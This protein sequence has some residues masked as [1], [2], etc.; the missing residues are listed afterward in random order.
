MPDRQPLRLSLFLLCLAL[1]GARLGGAHLHLCLDGQEALVS[2][3]ASEPGH[4]DAHHGDP[5]HSDVDVSLVSDALT[6]LAKL[7][8]DL[9]TLLAVLWLVLGAR[10][11]RVTA[12]STRL[13][14]RASQAR[15]HHPPLRGPPSLSR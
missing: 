1:L 3:H 2:A 8:V 5:A 13:P 14:G 7:F 9:P 4:D 15:F 11:L 6:P 12:P 10:A